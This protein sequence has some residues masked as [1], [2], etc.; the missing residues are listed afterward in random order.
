MSKTVKR[1]PDHR[2]YKPNK[3]KNGSAAAWQLKKE[4]T[5]TNEKSYVKVDVQLFLVLTN[6]SGYDEE[7]DNAEFYWDKD[8]SQTITMKLGMADVEALLAVLNRA[9]NDVGFNGKGLYHQ[10]SKGNTVLTMRRQD[11]DKGDPN[12]YVQVSSKRGDE[13]KRIGISISL[14]ESQSLRVFLNK[15]CEVFLGFD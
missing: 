15:C 2:I 9:K 14:E 3:S 13:L 5:V 7:K 12:Y 10:N 4:S 6:Q 8:E 1:W 11:R